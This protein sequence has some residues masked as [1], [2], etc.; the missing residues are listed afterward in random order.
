MLDELDEDVETSHSRMR[1]AQKKLRMVLRSSGN[2]RS[3]CTTILL[4]VGLAV[5]ILI[6]FKIVAFL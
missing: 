2:C 6:G 4:M 3:L 5:V 1:Q